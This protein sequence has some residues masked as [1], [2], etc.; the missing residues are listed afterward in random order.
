LFD[1]KAAGDGTLGGYA[2][3]LVQ[4]D[5][6][7]GNGQTH[8]VAFSRPN[9]TQIYVDVEI[10]TT[11]TFEG[12]NDVRDSLIQ[13]IGGTITSGDEE[14]GEIRVG[15]DVIYAKVLN[16]IMSI[17]GVAD[18]PSVTVGTSP[19]PTGTSNLAISSTDVA[20]GDATDSSITITEI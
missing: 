3:S 2:G 12:L 8:P 7:V 13:Y 11:D 17:N 10:K 19:S 1:S 16:A 15:D 6:N 4:I 5:A 18:A 20:T 9:V 14:D